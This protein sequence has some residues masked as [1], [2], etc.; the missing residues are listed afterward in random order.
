MTA[1]LYTDI[2]YFTAKEP[3]GADAS[4]LFNQLTGYGDPPA[5]RKVTAAPLGLRKKFKSLIE[6]MCIRDRA[7]EAC[8]Q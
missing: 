8:I 3:F 7:K 6:K 2:G 1:R 5:F 4:A